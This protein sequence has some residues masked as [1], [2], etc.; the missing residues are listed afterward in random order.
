MTAAE[1]GGSADQPEPADEIGSFSQLV[2]RAAE[3]RPD[4]AAVIEGGT[5]WSW[6]QL[7][8][9]VARVAAALV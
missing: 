6:G 7:A 1:H 8:D 2:R 4:Q 9:A 3:L 5:R